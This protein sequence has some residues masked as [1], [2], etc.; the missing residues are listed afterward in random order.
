MT[1][2]CVCCNCGR[3][4]FDDS[5]LRLMR[6]PDAPDEWMHACTRC[7][8]DACLMDIGPDDV[9]RRLDAGDRLSGCDGSP[10]TREAVLR[11]RAA[12]EDMKSKEGE[13]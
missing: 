2:W 5:E 9:M 11:A 8:T 13:E 6:D 10:L 1:D 12:E 7:L 3:L 4:F